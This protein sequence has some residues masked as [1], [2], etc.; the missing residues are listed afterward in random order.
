MVCAIVFVYNN[1]SC[2]TCHNFVCVND[3]IFMH[4]SPPAKILDMKYLFVIFSAFLLTAC[5]NSGA[6][7]AGDKDDAEKT[8]NPETILLTDISNS[9]DM[10]TLLC[11]NWENKEDAQEAAL[12]GGSSEFEM[13]YHGFS[14]FND[15]TVVQNPRDAI[16]FGKWTFDAG[17]KVVTINYTEGGSAKYKI[18]A[19]GAMDMMLVNMADNK[20]AEY[21][22]DGKVQKNIA[23]DPFYGA[24]N[25]WRKKPAKP[26]S[27]SALKNRLLQCVNFYNKFLNDNL[28]REGN[29]ISFVGLPAIFKW[30]AGGISVTSKNKLEQKWMNCFYNTAQAHKAQQMLEDIITKKYKWDKQEPNWVRKDAKVLQQIYDTLV[31]K[32]L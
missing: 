31:A 26:E 10:V 13:P 19:I 14:F 29:T 2:N 11:Q 21:Q 23:N 24:N 18:A 27:D 16:R 22:A 6:K 30:Y 7:Q 17:S 15:N 1:K 28:G 3:V 5:N 32:P 25:L 12:S 20:K 8:E 4:H 9:K